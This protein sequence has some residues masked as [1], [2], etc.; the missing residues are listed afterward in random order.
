M[1]RAAGAYIKSLTHCI[2]QNIGIIHTGRTTRNSRALKAGRVGIGKGKEGK[3]QRA[4]GHTTTASATT[5]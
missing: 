4:S 1:S 3:E 5:Q 2:A